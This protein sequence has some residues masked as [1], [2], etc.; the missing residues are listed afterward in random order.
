MARK[1][2]ENKKD[3]QHKQPVIVSSVTSWCD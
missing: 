3:K 2:K 1:A